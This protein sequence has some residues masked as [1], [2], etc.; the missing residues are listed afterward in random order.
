ME[1][2]IGMAYTIV[3]L[4]MWICDDNNK[5]LSAYCKTNLVLSS[6]MGREQLS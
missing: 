6:R 5:R 4:L 2:T 1:L 3:D